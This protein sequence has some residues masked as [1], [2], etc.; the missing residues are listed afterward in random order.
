MNNTQKRPTFNSFGLCL[1]I[2]CLRSRLA[3]FLITCFH[4]PHLQ[5][6]LDTLWLYQVEK[7]DLLKLK[8]INKNVC[9][10]RGTVNKIKKNK[11]KNK[12]KKTFVSWRQQPCMCFLK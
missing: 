12:T 2:S 8:K 4:R 3:V 10:I 6:L 1:T 7:N 5:K 9:V 11:K